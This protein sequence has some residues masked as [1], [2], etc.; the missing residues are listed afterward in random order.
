MYTDEKVA[1]GVASS[2]DLVRE[3]APAATTL[4]FH[5][6]YVRADRLTADAT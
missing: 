3:P 4:E 5:D 2:T 6:E 1:R